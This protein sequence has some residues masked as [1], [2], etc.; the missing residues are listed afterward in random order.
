MKKSSEFYIAPLDGKLRWWAQLSLLYLLI[1]WSCNYLLGLYNFDTMAFDTN[2]GKDTGAAIS[3]PLVTAFALFGNLL[4]RVTT[5]K[6]ISRIRYQ[7]A[8]HYLKY[9]T[10]AE[11]LLSSKLKRAT[12]YLLGVTVL[13]SLGY[14]STHQLYDVSNPL[15]VFTQARSVLILQTWVCWFFMLRLFLSIFYSTRMTIHF[16]STKIAVRLFRIDE[17]KPIS[18]IVMI[19][20]VAPALVVGIQ[21]LFWINSAAPELDLLLIMFALFLLLL[22]ISV[23]IYLIKKE[24][25]RKKM[26]S[27]ERI[28]DAIDAAL[29]ADRKKQRRLVDSDNRL[30]Y[31]SDL[32]TVRNEIGESKEWPVD[33]PFII[34]V[35]VLFCLPLI[36]WVASSLIDNLVKSLL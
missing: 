22:A 19:N 4:V 29:Q 35:S 28:N 21:P 7:K 15:S 20:F 23:P 34:K 36:G 27:I 11:K 6:A 8:A 12:P 13:L 24:L 33:I 26:L 25:K 1:C 2:A 3:L 32:L 31:V 14:F 5:A 30:Q 16:V 18:K 9:S 10:F 17:L